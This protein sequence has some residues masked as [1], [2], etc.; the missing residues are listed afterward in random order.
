MSESDTDVWEWEELRVKITT[1]DKVVKK[2]IELLDR[3]EAGYA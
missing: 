1:I 2:M 3:C